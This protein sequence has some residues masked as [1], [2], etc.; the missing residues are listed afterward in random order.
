MP[1]QFGIQLKWISK[2][3]SLQTCPWTQTQAFHN[4]SLCTC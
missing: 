3:Y 2:F 1:V 4:P